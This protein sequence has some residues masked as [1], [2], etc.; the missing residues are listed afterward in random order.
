MLPYDAHDEHSPSYSDLQSY[1]AHDVDTWYTHHHE[2]A[3]A[4]REHELYGHH[5]T[6]KHHDEP[7]IDDH[8]DDW[9]LSYRYE[10]PH[11]HAPLTE[12]TRD[13]EPRPHDDDFY[14]FDWATIHH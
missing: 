10:A 3:L 2:G 12:A 8:Y 1:H 14:S 4:K 5:F 13:L 6:P 9:D 7:A 11:L